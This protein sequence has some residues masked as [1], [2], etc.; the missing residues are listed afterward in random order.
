[1]EAYDEA[2][3]TCS[4]VKYSNVDVDGR[5]IQERNLLSLDMEDRDS[6]VNTIA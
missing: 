6:Y 5:I 4:D 2:I 3:E 1:M